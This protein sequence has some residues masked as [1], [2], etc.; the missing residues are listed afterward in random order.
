MK[1][2]TLK[3]LTIFNTIKKLKRFALYSLCATLGV[4]MVHVN[5]K[6]LS[7]ENIDHYLA[8]AESNYSDIVDGAN[9]HVR[10]Y[11]SQ[12]KKTEYAI[13]YLHGFSASRQELSPTTENFVDQLGANAFYTRL[14]GHGRS[15]DA[16]AEAS[17][18]KWQTDTLEAYKI[19]KLIGNK[20]I[21]ISTS[22]GGTLATWLLTQDNVEQ[23]FANIMISP[24]FAVQ[25]N[26]AWLLKSSWGLKIAKLINGDY[27]SF[28]PISEAH[29]KYW[30][31]R[32]PLEA[33]QP[34]L[35]LLDEVES[36]DKS[37]VRAP[38]LIIYSPKDKVIDVDEILKVE[39]KFIN[40]EATLLAFDH[41]TDPYQH[42]LSGIACSPESTGDM[43]NA[44]LKYV[45]KLAN[46][47]N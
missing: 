9:K 42:V 2:I 13:V 41:S 35:K 10:W 16:M 18:E 26:S 37:K 3:H 8:N 43:T 15:D 32:Y 5:A 14:T 38:Q 30:T 47:N 29:A 21:I 36:T 23:P 40:S 1:H 33:V 7:L 4:N 28:T 24:N 34:M 20:V 31:E 12:R 39:Q 45:Q 22:T 25:N 46:V 27:N 44:I 6:E 17:T 11:Q 19:G